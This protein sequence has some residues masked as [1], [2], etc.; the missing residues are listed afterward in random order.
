M[1]IYDDV[2]DLAEILYEE[3]I[4][5]AK[6]LKTQEDINQ[7][8]QDSL[9]L[10]VEPVYD[11]NLSVMEQATIHIDFIRDDFNFKDEDNEL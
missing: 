6:A 7:Y 1:Y 4:E 5:S 9:D 8:K 2:Y 10:I 11:A 3:N